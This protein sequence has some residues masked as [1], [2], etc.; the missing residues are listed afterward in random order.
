VELPSTEGAD[1]ARAATRPLVDIRHLNKIYEPSPRWLSF[2]LRSAISEPVVAL[3][4]VTFTVDAGQICA[5]VGPNGAGKSTLFRVLTGL[6]TPT[7]GSASIAGFDCTHESVEVRR[8]I[9]FMPPEDRTLF[10]RYDCDENL[11]FHGRLQGM[12]ER[13]LRQR[14]DEILELVGLTHART[15]AGFALSSGM[16]ARLQLARAMLHRPRVLILDEPTGTVDPIAAHEFLELLVTTATEEGVAIL[17]SSHRLEEIE[18]LDDN[19]VMIDQGRVAYSGDL[20]ELRRIW[21]QPVLEL[22]FSDDVSARQARDALAGLEVQLLP[23]EGTGVAV[24]TAL[25]AGVVLAELGGLVS[26]V[27]KLNQRRM[28]FRELLLLAYQRAPKLTPTGNGATPDP[29]PRIGSPAC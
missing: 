19:L 10:L 21:E 29:A 9:G 27:T 4:D 22:E 1:A 3:D 24:A 11:M 18:S 13:P 23:S 6:T 25:P 20:D 26:S 7:G 5:V 17:I 2:L 12:A 15:R 28:P 16:R 14:V 8:L